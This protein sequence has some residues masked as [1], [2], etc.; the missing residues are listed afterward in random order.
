MAKKNPSI[1]AT[2]QK[3]AESASAVNGELVRTLPVDA[4]EDNPL[5]R[6]SMEEDEQFL[7][8]VA[9]VEKDGFLEDIIVTPAGEGRWR[10]VSGHRRAAA[11]RRLGKA[12]VPCK[13][14][15][16]PDQ[17]SELRALMGA[18]LH[19]RNLS[20]FDM[21]RQLETL[22]EVLGREGLLPE[23]VKE[24]AELMAEQTELSRATVE[25]YLDLLNLDETLTAWA[26][27]G[28]MTMTDAYE[29][30]R[31]KNQP[32]YPAVESFVDNVKNRVEKPEEFSALVHRAIAFAKA[33]ENPPPPPRAEA[34]KNPLR[35]VDSFGRSI[36]R[37]TAQ[38]KALDLK[39]EA[40]REAARK[41][42]E[43]CLQNLEELRRTVE[44]LRDTLS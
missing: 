33:A 29:L 15:T 32:L 1:F 31:K 23:N 10:I 3:T 39:E 42:L 30:A 18:N 4:L 27:E 35:T 16:Y 17:L 8:T 34:G 22:R 28:R 38:M 43:T 40:D 9:S 2:L 20:P 6:F 37:S 11:A 14:R 19:R 13:V 5:N 44:A 25:R 36:R 26:R 12:S 24:Q 7:A 41:K 21:A